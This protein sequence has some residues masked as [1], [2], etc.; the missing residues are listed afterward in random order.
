MLLQRVITY[1]DIKAKAN[2]RFLIY[3]K[4][5]DYMSYFLL[6]NFHDLKCIFNYYDRS[7]SKV[8]FKI[9]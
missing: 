5:D 4:V 8:S 1:D 7:S 3:V 2:D 9:K 6:Y